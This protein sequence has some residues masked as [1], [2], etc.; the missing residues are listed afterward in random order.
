MGIHPNDIFSNSLKP[1]Y[2]NQDILLSCDFGGSKF[3]RNVSIMKVQM[4]Y[5]I[6]LIKNLLQ[7]AQ[8]T[9]AILVFTL[10]KQC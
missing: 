10:I 2:Q 5:V 4:H 8:V 3:L 9:L 6:S 1:L 7:M